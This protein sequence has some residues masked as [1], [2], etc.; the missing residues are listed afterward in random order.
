MHSVLVHIGTVALDKFEDA[1][2]ALA[3]GWAIKNAGAALDYFKRICSSST[4]ILKKS[5]SLS[6]VFKDTLFI[7]NSGISGAHSYYL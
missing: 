4:T 6:T 3:V 1:C 2:A 7:A 5:T